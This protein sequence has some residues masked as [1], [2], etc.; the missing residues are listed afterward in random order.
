MARGCLSAPRCI[1]SGLCITVYRR[2][3][4]FFGILLL[5]ALFHSLGPTK[6]VSGHV[7]PN[8]LL[9]AGMQL[10]LNS[11]SPGGQVSRLLCSGKAAC[12]QAIGYLILFAGKQENA[13][14]FDGIVACMLCVKNCMVMMCGAAKILLHI[15]QEGH[16]RV[17]ACLSQLAAFVCCKFC[18]KDSVL[19]SSTAA[20]LFQKEV[21]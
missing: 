9:R 19:G 16:C 1:S 17:W 6:A 5:F 21:V 13:M 20:K 2:L 11:A 4:N 15:H 3:A 18:C 10:R 12:E 8:S 14:R 7:K